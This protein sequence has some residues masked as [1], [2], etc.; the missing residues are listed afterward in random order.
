MLLIS[1]IKEADS[2]NNYL[3]N[4]FDP[5]L[6]GALPLQLRSP[7]CKKR[8]TKFIIKTLC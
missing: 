1:Q 6:Q 3:H 5:S 4:I 8:Q 7:F 2:M